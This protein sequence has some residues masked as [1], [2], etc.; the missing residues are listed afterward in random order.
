[1]TTRI[2]PPTFHKAKNKERFR[3]ELLAWKEIT[4]LSNEKQGIVIALSLPEDDDS[5]IR[6]KV[7]DQIPV[8]DLKSA[9]GLTVLLNFL[10][11]HLAKDDLTDCLEKFED[12]EDFK[13]ADGQSINEYVAMFDAKY[14]KIEKKKMTLPSE[15]LA[16]KLLRKAN[17]TKEEK[18]L[19]L[20][21]MNYDNKATLY[22][23]AKYL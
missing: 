3:Q 17:I 22:E 20:T 5:Q 19:V 10:D 7:F 21:G 6:E 2:N 14:R 9:D 16:F 15:I 13:R 4:D 23:E 12:F 1:M 11:K 18:L 8:D